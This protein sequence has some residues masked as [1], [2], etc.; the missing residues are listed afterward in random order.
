MSGPILLCVDGSELSIQA[1]AAG[2]AVV[3]HDGPFALVTVMDPPDP[4]LVT[5]TGFAGGVMSTEEYAGEQAAAQERADAVLTELEGQLGLPHVTHHVLEG[6]PGP[7]V[8]QLADEVGA[9][10][11]VLGS[12]G[13]GGLRRAVLGSVSD[14]VVRN[15]TCPVVVTGAGATDA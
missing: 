12:R 15:A 8:V 2:L 5:G 14:H 6:E 11:I 13:R 4:T 7:A 1:V 10:A 9:R 3:D